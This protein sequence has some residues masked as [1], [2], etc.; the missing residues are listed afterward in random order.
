MANTSSGII[1]SGIK[2]PAPM[3]PPVD[4]DSLKNTTVQAEWFR[5]EKGVL[6]RFSSQA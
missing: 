3:I 1:A 2:E 6:A 5:I 4:L